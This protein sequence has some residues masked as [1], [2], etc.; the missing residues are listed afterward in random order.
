MQRPAAPLAHVPYSVYKRIT[1]DYHRWTLTTNWL[2]MHIPRSLHENLQFLIIEVRTQLSNLGLYFESY[3]V[4][5]A[6]RIIDRSGY[7]HNLKSSIHASCVSLMMHHESVPSE[8][9]LL[10]SLEIIAT[11]LDRISELCREC[12]QQVGYLKKRKHLP[13]KL[14]ITLLRRIST[15]VKLIDGAISK[16]N[17]A[18]ALKI[19]RIEHKL[20][21]A[22]KKL[23][24]KHISDLKGNDK[25][26]TE[27]LVSALFIAHSIEQMGDVLL[28]SSEAIISANLG[29]PLNTNR[30]QSLQASIAQ[31]DTLAADT[32]TTLEPVAMTRSGSGISGINTTSDSGDAC[33]AIFKDG[34]QRKVK[35]ERDGVKNWHEIFPGLA[36]KILSYHK[37]GQSAALLIEHLAGHTFE[38]ILLHEP[39]KLLNQSMRQLQKTLRSIWNETHTPKAVSAHYMKQLQKRL[40]D[41]Y[42]LHPEFA[43][44]GSQIGNSRQPSFDALL[45]QAMRYEK[46]LKA[47]FSVYIHGDFNVDNIIYDPLEKRINFIDLHRSTYMDYVQDISVFMVSNYR[48]RVEDPELRQRILQQSYSLY[49]FAARY[50]KKAGDPTFEQRLALGLARSFATSTRFVLDRTLSRSMWLRARYLLESVLQVSPQQTHFR[51]PIRQI[52]VT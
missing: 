19:G 49:Q 7:T 5:V 52:F 15:G 33:L 27:D 43:H 12:I 14:Y 45:E 46:Q 17:T 30:Y 9:G 36:P 47:P 18:Q 3:S 8:T 29:Q 4:T 39:S 11:D 42:A 31:L 50:A 28:S 6:K 22:Y 23:L 1:P 44:G 13:S 10:R 32:E 35:E 40:A 51:L 38:Q 25:H 48:L 26:R 21:C 37:Q 20:D 24:K 34:Q 16:N 41:V 2:T